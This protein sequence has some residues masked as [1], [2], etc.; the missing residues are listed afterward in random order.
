MLV[1]SGPVDFDLAN[2]AERMCAMELAGLQKAFE[3]GDVKSSSTKAS[4]FDV[5]LTCP[6]RLLDAYGAEST[7]HEPATNANF[8]LVNKIVSLLAQQNDNKVVAQVTK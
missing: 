5:T 1:N 4:F 2:E 7:L 8:A 3:D 6:Q